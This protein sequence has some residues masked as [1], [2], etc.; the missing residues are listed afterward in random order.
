MTKPR[1]TTYKELNDR[2]TIAFDKIIEIHSNIDY[3]HT[4]V[5]KYI[6]FK[7]DETELRKYLEKQKEKGNERKVE[8]SKGEETSELGKG[9][10]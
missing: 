2:L 9:Q 10:A 8:Q 6:E 4:L 3:V 1:K 7:G 5:M